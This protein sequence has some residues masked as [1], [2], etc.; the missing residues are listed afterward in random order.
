MRRAI[1]ARTERRLE[2]KHHKH[3]RSSQLS[4]NRCF[5]NKLNVPQ[6][7]I[8]LLKRSEVVHMARPYLKALR[9]HW[10]AA[11]AVVFALSTRSFASVPQERSPIPCV[12]KPHRWV[13]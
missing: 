1:R 13:G 4:R 6:H 7:N 8:P 5:S 12:T 3:G 2:R 9:F 11:S 10:F